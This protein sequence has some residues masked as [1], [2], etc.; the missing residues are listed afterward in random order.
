MFYNVKVLC[1]DHAANV[2]YI[3]QDQKGLAHW[4][5][6]ENFLIVLSNIAWKKFWS[7]DVTI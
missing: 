2:S 5:G 4:F 3:Y 7:Y 6:D 1:K